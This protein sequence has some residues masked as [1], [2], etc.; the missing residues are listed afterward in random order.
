MTARLTFSLNVP[1][2]TRPGEDAPFIAHCPLLDVSAQGN[3]EPEALDG[4][5]EALQLFLETCY[6]AGTLD[7]VLMDA[8]FTRGDGDVE[9]D[10]SDAMTVPFEL[11][12]RSGRQ[13]A[14]A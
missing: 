6:F 2:Q 4:L 3:S 1:V 5:R 13:A 14:C 8:G 9:F 10:D 12:A 11:I 7:Q